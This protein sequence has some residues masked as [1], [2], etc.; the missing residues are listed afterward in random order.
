MYKIDCEQLQDACNLSSYQ[1][2]ICDDPV[3]MNTSCALI[4][5][6]PQFV[7]FQELLHT[8]KL[9]MRGSEGGGGRGVVIV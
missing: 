7:V 2:T 8:T 5:A 9:F 3:Y 4:H 1:C 6:E